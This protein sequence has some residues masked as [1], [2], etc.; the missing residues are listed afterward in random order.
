MGWAIASTS[1]EVVRLGRLDPA[2]VVR[3]VELGVGDP[4]G[5]AEAEGRGDDTLAETGHVDD[6]LLEARH[7]ALPVGRLVEQGDGGDRRAEHGIVL[8]AP[9]HGVGRVHRLA[10]LHQRGGYGVGLVIVHGDVRHGDPPPRS[11]QGPSTCRP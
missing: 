10:Q 2:Q 6:G 1:R 11:A 3:E 9:Q 4:P 8:D 5:R 7:E